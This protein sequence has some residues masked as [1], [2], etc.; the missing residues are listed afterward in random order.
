MT[1]TCAKSV[2]KSSA[3]RPESRR[4]HA[5]LPQDSRPP[6]RRVSRKGIRSRTDTAS[7]S[8]GADMGS[9]PDVRP[10]LPA[11]V[12]H[13]PAWECRTGCGRRAGVFRGSKGSASSPRKLG[14]GGQFSAP[15]AEMS[16]T[17]HACSP[18]FASSMRRLRFHAQSRP[19]GQG[20]S[21][22]P[23]VRS[24]GCLAES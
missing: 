9:R 22:R 21:K 1:S 18:S 13:L 17:A 11:N 16:V 23:S 7:S 5:P 3:C 15:C 12:R 24:F 2:S 8:E 4:R 10:E 20:K 19:A 6:V 14:G